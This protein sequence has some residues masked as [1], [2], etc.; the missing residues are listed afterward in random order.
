MPRTRT[1]WRPGTSGNPRGKPNVLRRA[2]SLLRT[3]EPD[4]ALAFL[5]WQLEARPYRAAMAAREICRVALGEPVRRHWHP[6]G[7]RGGAST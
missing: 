6:P 3:G 4:A 5:A 1:T 2:R 7:W